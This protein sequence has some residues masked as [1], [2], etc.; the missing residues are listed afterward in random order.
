[1][2]NLFN[3]FKKEGPKI[4]ANKN[5]NFNNIFNKKIKIKIKVIFLII[6]NN[7][8]DQVVAKAIRLSQIILL[9]LSEVKKNGEPKFKYY[10]KY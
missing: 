5:I 10:L 8:I 6:V 4:I 9:I 3:N 2:K 7:K 1:M